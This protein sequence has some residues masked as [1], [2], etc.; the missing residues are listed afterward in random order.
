MAQYPALPLFTDAIMADCY[1]LS[2][3]EFG[4]YS[5]ILILMWRTP[6][7]RIPNDSEWI[8]KRL[9]RTALQFDTEIRPILKE[10]CI[11]DGNFWTQKRLSK[12]Y[13][14]VGSQSAKGKKGADARW[15]KNGNSAMK[16]NS[17]NR[18]SKNSVSDNSLNNDD[19]PPHSGICQTDAPTPTP[20]PHKESIIKT[21]LTPQNPIKIV[22]KV[23][24]SLKYNN[25]V[26]GVGVYDV[27]NHLDKMDI[28]VCK[29]LLEEI[30]PRWDFD[31]LVRVYNTA[32]NTRKR[33]PPDKPDKAFPKWLRLYTKG[34]P[35]D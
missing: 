4:L 34:K 30:S 12:E 8:A 32:I 2:D 16:K 31:T 18:S 24:R 1:H 3:A 22:D 5:R 10:F 7:C 29:S 27:R 26:S 6:N 33:T 13:E 28:V 25:N 21:P 9:G 15:G 20:T 14:Y 35:P 11:C 23:S 17:E 19:S